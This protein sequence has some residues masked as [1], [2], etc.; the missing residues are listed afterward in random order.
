MACGVVCRVRV[1]VVRVVHTFRHLNTMVGMAGVCLFIPLSHSIQHQEVCQALYTTVT[2][3]E[4]IF[5][6]Y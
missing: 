3:L 2:G 1:W 4:D 6:M 5:S